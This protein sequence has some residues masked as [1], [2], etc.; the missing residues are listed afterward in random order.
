[1]RAAVPVLAALALMAAP[2]A[3]AGEATLAELRRLA[4]RAAADERALEELRQVDRVDGVAVD[5]QTAL[6]GADGEELERRL[7]ALAA[8]GGGAGG[9]APSGTEA[10]EAAAEILA[11]RR[12]DEAG[13]PRPF[14]RLLDWLGERLRPLARP[15]DRLAQWIP[16]GASVLWTALGLVVV[17]AAAA[18]TAW[19]GRRRGGAVVAR[20]ARADDG[21]GLDPRRLDRLA[22][23]AEARGELELA[24]RLRFRAGLVRLAQRR[25]VPSPETLTSRQLVRLLGSEQFERLARDLDEVVYGGRAATPADVEAARQGWP[26]VLA[27]APRP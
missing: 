1:M 10:R 19:L 8:G 5:L 11:E 21:S 24:L 18:F 3:L 2:A 26:A 7:A 27:G 20:L 17:V 25:A 16:G 12:F 9:T 6:A 13:P 4:A 23:A 15:F 22:E 14:R